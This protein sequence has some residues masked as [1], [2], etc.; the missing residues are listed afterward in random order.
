MSPQTPAQ[1]KLQ[2]LELLLN[3]TTVLRLEM[4]T[5]RQQLLELLAKFPPK[6]RA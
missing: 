3:K 1:Q 4:Q 5:T 2:H 6:K